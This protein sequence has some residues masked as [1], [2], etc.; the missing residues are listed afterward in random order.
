M[1]IIT[2][3]LALEE[4]KRIAKKMFGDMVKAVVDVDREL[5]PNSIL[6]LKHCF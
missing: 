4:L 6:I 2:K 1:Q 5:T 3:Q